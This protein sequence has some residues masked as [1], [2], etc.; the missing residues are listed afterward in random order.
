[1]SGTG[2]G[3]AAMCYAMCGTDIRY[4]ATR[5]SR[6]CLSQVSLR[7][8]IAVCAY[9]AVRMRYAMSGTDL[10]PPMVVPGADP[11]HAT[12]REI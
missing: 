5:S 10:S 1:M 3:Y 6:R 2:I 11:A 4:A 12:R 7:R 8:H 9:H